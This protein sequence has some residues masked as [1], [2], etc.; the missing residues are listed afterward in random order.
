MNRLGIAD[1]VLFAVNLAIGA[2]VGIYYLFK[3]RRKRQ[4]HRGS[5][6]LLEMKNKQT[7]MNTLLSTDSTDPKKDCGNTNEFGST[8][9]YFVASSGTLSLFQVCC[10]LFASNYSAVALLGLPA[11]YYTTGSIMLLGSPAYGISVIFIALVFIPVFYNNKFST[12]FEYVEVRFKSPVL[13]KMTALGSACCGIAYAAVISIIYIFFIFFFTLYFFLFLSKICAYIPCAVFSGATQIPEWILILT[14][15][16]VTL[17]Y[18][19]I[20]R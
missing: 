19:V 7:V 13:R 15:S 11:E 18:T 10:S 12:I 3:D 14:I 5:S 17:F 1:Y 9:D 20:V 16:V 4:K 6:T 8:D 2:A